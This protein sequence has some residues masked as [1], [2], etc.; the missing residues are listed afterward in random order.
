[1]A[2][3]KAMARPSA[4]KPMPMTSMGDIIPSV[5]SSLGGTHSNTTGGPPKPTLLHTLYNINRDDTV[6]LYEITADRYKRNLNVVFASDMIINTCRSIH[7]RPL[8]AC[9]NLF[10]AEDVKE[11]A[12]VMK[13][14]TYIAPR[15][16]QPKRL[17]TR[18]AVPYMHTMDRMFEGYSFDSDF[19]IPLIVYDR[20]VKTI[21]DMQMHA[22]DDMRVKKNETYLHRMRQ[23]LNCDVNQL[24]VN[25]QLQMRMGA[26]NVHLCHL[27]A[28]AASADM[29]S[30]IDEIGTE[31]EEC[32][33]STA[34]DIVVQKQLDQW[35][36][37]TEKHT[38]V[39]EN[40]IAVFNEHTSTP[41]EGGGLTITVDGDG[42]DELP[43]GAV[44]VMSGMV[45]LNVPTFRGHATYKRKVRSLELRNED[46]GPDRLVVLPNIVKQAFPKY[47]MDSR[48]VVKEH[49]RAD[50]PAK[51]EEKEIASST[52][53]RAPVTVVLQRSLSSGVVLLDN[54]SSVYVVKKD[55]PLNPLVSKLTHVTQCIWNMANGHAG[56]T[57]NTKG[58]FMRS[59]KMSHVFHEIGTHD[60]YVNPSGREVKKISSRTIKDAVFNDP[61]IYSPFF[62]QCFNTMYA[63]AKKLSTTSPTR[64]LFSKCMSTA[65]DVYQDAHAWHAQSRKRHVDF[66]SAGN[67]DKIMSELHP[68]HDALPDGGKG[69]KAYNRLVHGNIPLY[70]RPAPSMLLAGRALAQN[71]WGDDYQQHKADINTAKLLA[72][73][74]D[75]IFAGIVPTSDR[76]ATHMLYSLK[77]QS[78]LPPPS[79]ATSSVASVYAA[80]PTSLIHGLCAM[81]FIMPTHGLAAR[82]QAYTWKDTDSNLTVKLDVPELDPAKYTVGA[83]STC[84]IFHKLSDGERDG[85]TTFSYMVR[86][87]FH[88]LTKELRASTDCFAV[89]M[90][91]MF[92]AWIRLTAEG[93]EFAF[94]HTHWPLAAT[95][96]SYKKDDT[97]HVMVSRP[98]SVVSLADVPTTEI[99]PQDDMVTVSSTAHYKM[100]C[101]GINSN[102]V[103]ALHALGSSRT[104]DFRMVASTPPTHM[105][106]IKIA[107]TTT[108]PF[109]GYMQLTTNSHSLKRTHQGEKIITLCGEQ[110][111]WVCPPVVPDAAFQRPTNP[112]GRSSLPRT[113]DTSLVDAS[114]EMHDPTRDNG[115]GV[116]TLN[117]YATL[118]GGYVFCVHADPNGKVGEV[119]NCTY[120]GNRAASRAA[121]FFS[122]PRLMVAANQDGRVSSSSLANRLSRLPCSRRVIGD[123]K[124]FPTTIDGDSCNSFMSSWSEATGLAQHEPHASNPFIYA[125]MI[126]N[127]KADSTYAARQVE[128]YNHQYA[129]PGHTFYAKHKNDASK[130]VS[131]ACS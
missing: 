20:L 87:A 97:R 25:T 83:P 57:Q 13:R 26:V 17:A 100:A 6:Q 63:S 116:S 3:R 5:L 32:C 96:L 122:P 23:E 71:I 119:N 103:I 126:S 7:E 50:V 106:D 118:P 56:S 51:E 38:D 110:V 68:Y 29:L 113:S 123:Q 115:T 90:C 102:A 79:G 67:G 11:T 46:Y 127:R 12:S 78:T 47:E 34:L 35:L 1:M 44:L 43:V 112:T 117:P 88:M 36:V 2:G 128:W 125:N 40:T 4:T 53:H 45:P 92:C 84:C 59:D 99:L 130:V 95:V 37:P 15:V 24:L 41:T 107:D 120:R 33:L 111:A 72:K 80:E 105:K 131:T 101:D 49:D 39:I 76:G 121:H 69:L 21:R 30:A 60:L 52:Y 85:A 42:G 64:L 86:P 61:Y 94:D 109:R 66:T 93:T 89:K 108:P 129:I 73:D 8:G 16:P 98:D 104:T 19:I 82:G 14:V 27:V 74:I 81:P 9:V 91:A 28:N 18:S 48:V 55:Q 114:V 62:A 75:A 70:V 124:K 77:D 54:V 65:R 10:L 58:D 22:Q 31:G